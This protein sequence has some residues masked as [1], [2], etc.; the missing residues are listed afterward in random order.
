MGISFI[1]IPTH[2]RSSIGRRSA[3]LVRGEDRH[4][5]WDPDPE[6]RFDLDPVCVAAMERSLSGYMDRAVVQEATR[7]A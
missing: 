2:V 4:G 3:L 6:P 5:N 7:E 1:Y